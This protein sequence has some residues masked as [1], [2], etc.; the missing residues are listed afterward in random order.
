M[1]RAPARYILLVHLA[2]AIVAAVMMADLLGLPAALR[3]GPVLL[4]PLG[5]ARSR[6]CY[7]W[8][9]TWMR[10]HP[11]VPLGCHLWPVSFAALGTGLILVAALLVVAAL[12]GVRWAPWCL[13]VFTVADLTLWGYSFIWRE[14]PQ[15]LASFIERLQHP[16]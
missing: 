9:H 1:F 2:L 11:A 12:R 3:P 8:P 5:V 7:R 14:R 6:A 4:W 16:P 15:P 13:A 10:I